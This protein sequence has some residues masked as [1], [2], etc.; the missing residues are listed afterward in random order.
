MNKKI[1]SGVFAFALLITA[2]YGVNMNGKSDAGLSELALG[3]EERLAQVTIN[4]IRGTCT[5]TLSS[6]CFYRCC[7]WR[8]I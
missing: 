2:G 1:L 5:G 7:V 8:F 6:Y 3:N 4:E